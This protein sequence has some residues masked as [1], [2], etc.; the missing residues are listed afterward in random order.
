MNKL[1]LNDGIATEWWMDY[2]TG[3]L[4]REK[5][6]E[7]FQYLHGHPQLQKELK[8]SEEIW[9]DLGEVSVP[10]PSERMDAK[11]EA[12]L[13][14]YVAANE[15]NSAINWLPVL[16]DWVSRS[17]RVGLASLILGS[18]LGWFVIPDTKEDRQLAE[19]STE[20][21]EMKKMMMLTLI[22]QPK[23]QERIR[24][25]SLAGDLPSADLR[26]IEVLA[27]TLNRDENLNVRLAALESLMKYWDYSE[28]RSVLVK[29]ISLQD[30]P[31][32]QAAIADAMLILREKSAI[33][34]F[35]KLLAKPELN[36]VVKEKLQLTVEKLQQ[37]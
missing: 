12:M 11:F 21:Q 7:L 29:S 14:G 31:L 34:E 36:E 35:E 13:L 23:A 5:E 32:I 33:D 3:E 19:L 22:E 30:S 25:V 15:R 28:A 18:A 24:A 27:E 17:W 10:G 2:L 16:Q 9:S 1:I 26:V 8:I 4:D 20:V 37:I 6:G